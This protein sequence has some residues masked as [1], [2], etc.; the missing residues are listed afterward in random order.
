[1]ADF[2]LDVPSGAICALVG[3]N[4]AG[5]S[6]T[7][8]ML[9][10]LLPP[11]SGEAFVDGV[12]VT[13]TPWRLRRRIGCLPED[14]GLFADLT[15]EEH[16]QLTGDVY[17]LNRAETDGRATQ[18]LRIFNLEDG[19]RTF[20]RSCSQGMRKK[21][22][23]AMAL[24]PNPRVLILD[25]PFEAIEPATARVIGSLLQSFAGRG[26]TILLSSHILAIVERIA[27]QITILRDG[28][29]AWNSTANP[30]PSTLEELYFELAEQPRME[31]PW[32]LGRP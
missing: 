12:S 7:L 4:G 9:S 19:R 30:L 11:G 18:L 2:S 23:L 25:E 15:V 28:R 10:G 32:W 31:D 17:G 27:T 13:G 3:P 14:L 29:I 8:K 1:V 24:L 5:K 26:G 22:A 16:L 21:T 6:T 20:A